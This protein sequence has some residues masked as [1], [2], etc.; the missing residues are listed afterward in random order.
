MDEMLIKVIEQ[1]GTLAL[2]GFAIWT[3]NKVWKD[4]L[5]AEKRHTEQIKEM[6]SQTYAAI[7][8]NVEAI[9]KLT[10]RLK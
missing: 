4:R 8:A 9:T 6:W 10:E 5:E 7:K 1:G 3:L 2:A